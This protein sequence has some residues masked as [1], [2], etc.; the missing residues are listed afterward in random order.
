MPTKTFT[1]QRVLNVMDYVVKNEVNGI[2]TERDFLLSIGYKSVVNVNIVRA[3]GQS[4]TIKHLV[5]ACE[6]YKVDANYFLNKAHIKM[7]QVNGQINPLANLKQAVRMIE[8][9]LAT[10]QTKPPLKRKVKQK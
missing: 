4:F 2:T 10:G 1:D 3:G 9:S 8:D 7:M 6:V 5:K